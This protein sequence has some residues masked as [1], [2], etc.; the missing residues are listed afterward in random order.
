VGALAG[1]GAGG[2]F[3]SEPQTYT[4]LVT[5]TSGSVSHAALTVTLIIQ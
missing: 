3:G 5:A 4:I 1:C 2:L